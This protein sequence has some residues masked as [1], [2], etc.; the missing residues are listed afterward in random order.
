LAKVVI[1]NCSVAEQAR[2]ARTSR[3]NTRAKPA[4]STAITALHACRHYWFG[5]KRTTQKP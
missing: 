2:S 5:A 1:R 3:A 4:W